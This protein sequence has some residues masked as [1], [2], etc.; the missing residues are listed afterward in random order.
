MK[1]S[2]EFFSPAKGGKSIIT[3]NENTLTISRP[4]LISKMALGFKGDKTIL[5]NQ[6]SA[7]QIK[8]VGFARGYIQFIIAG[9]K[10][11]KSGIVSGKVDENTVYSDS[12]FKKSNNE[13][14]AEF[15]EIKNYIEN[16]NSSKGN[17]TTIVQNVKTPIEQVKDLKELL[18][19]GAITQEE[20]DKKKKELLNL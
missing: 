6:I 15:E 16:F 1:K 4:G 2:Y 17:Y 13:I 11:S 14:N 18:D 10:E 7:V 9:A 12:S 8:K 5:I 19:I 20:F 3:I